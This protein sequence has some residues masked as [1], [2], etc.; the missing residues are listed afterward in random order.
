MNLSPSKLINVAAV[1]GTVV[2]C[3]VLGYL[4]GYTTVILMH[5]FGFI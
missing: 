3:G 4:V 5:A 2:A 1:A